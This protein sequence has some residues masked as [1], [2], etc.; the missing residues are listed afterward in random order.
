MYAQSAH[1]RF[2]NLST[3]SEALEPMLP[4]LLRISIHNKADSNYYY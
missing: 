1:I 3:E 4:D 2:R